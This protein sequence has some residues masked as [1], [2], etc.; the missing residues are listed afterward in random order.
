LAYEGGVLWF[1]GPNPDLIRNGADAWLRMA[2]QAYGLEQVVIA[3]VFV[4]LIFA[5]WSWWRRQDRPDAVLGV[6]CGM[7]LECFG[8]AILLWG[9]SHGLAPMLQQLGVTLAQPPTIDP[10]MARLVTFIGAGIYE[11]ILFR[12]LLFSGLTILL[13]LALTPRFQALLIAAV[14]SAFVFAAAHH[15]GP[16]GEPMNSYVFLFRFMAGMYFA[17]VYHFRGFAVAAGAH[18]CYDVLVG[19]AP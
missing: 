8:F 4:A 3:P 15:V 11:E 9:L 12:F 2:L 17:A 13:R 18:A 19:L 1:G 7:G 10:V 16:Y 5:V 14:I 6:C